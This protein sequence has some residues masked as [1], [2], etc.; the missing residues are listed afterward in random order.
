MFEHGK[1]VAFDMVLPQLKFVSAKQVL[2]EFSK[3]SAKALNISEQL[4][5][6]KLWEQEQSMSS[7]TGDGVAIVHLKII[8][9]LQPFLILATLNRELDFQAHDGQPVNIV[10]FILSPEKDG[11]LHLRRLSR[12]SRLLNHNMLK[13][14]LLDAQDEFAMRALLIDPEGWMLAA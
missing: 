1:N 14:R 7:A 2:M 4:L 3:H 11:P 8:G 13:K 9:P 12:I 10:A 5:F 6:A